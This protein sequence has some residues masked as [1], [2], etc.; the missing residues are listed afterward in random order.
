MKVRFTSGKLRVR[1]DDLEVAALQGEER[2]TEHL[3]WPGGGWTL[4]LDP[5]TNGVAGEGGT[6]TVG[7]RELLPHLL[8]ED[9]E[10]VT[11]P[12]PPRVDVEK[13][14]GPQHV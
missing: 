4:T 1:L 7:L 9:R 14:Y 12:G 3:T 10:G 8:E 11:L 6:L 2:L 5:T 13:E